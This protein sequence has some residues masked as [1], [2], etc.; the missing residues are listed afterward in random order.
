[1]KRNAAVGFFT[2]PSSLIGGDRIMSRI[3]AC[4]VLMFLVMAGCQQ[5]GLDFK[6][7]YKEIHGLKAKDPVIEGKNTIG[8]VTGI[9]STKDARYLVHVRIKADYADSVTEHSSFYIR[10]DLHKG[11]GTV[12][13][14]VQTRSGGTPL[15][16]GDTIEGSYE[17]VESSEGFWKDFEGTLHD[18]GRQL[19]EFSDYIR[20]FPDSREYRSLKR[21][22]E[23][24]SEEMRQ[25]EK[26]VREKIEKDLLPQLQQDLEK[27][28]DALKKHK[29]R[30]EKPAR[31]REDLLEKT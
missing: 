4:L 13:E 8:E 23:R 11:A 1:M 20:E 14:M 27:L 2:K 30:E 29:Q 31:P 12:I 19:D 25:A 18:L 5:G 17:P 10:K 3:F 24:L 16:D 6:I 15:R 9:S 26:D 22:L 7:R 28:R 21:Q